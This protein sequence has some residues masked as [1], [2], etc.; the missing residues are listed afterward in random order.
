MQQESW[1]IKP[2]IKHFKSTVKRRM[3]R[4]K[5]D[6]WVGCADGLGVIKHALKGKEF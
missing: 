5:T 4:F 2:L 1:E 3:K 6:G